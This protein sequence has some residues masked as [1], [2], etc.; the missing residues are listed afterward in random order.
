M[1]Y[2]VCIMNPPYDNG[3]GNK[4]FDRCL[5]TAK[6]VVTIQ[7]LSWLLAKRQH[8]SITSKID[9]RKT[10]IEVVNGN[11]CFDAGICAHVA[12]T[13]ISDESGKIH[14]ADKVFD[15]CSDIKIYSHDDCLTEFANSV[16]FES[17]LWDNVKDTQPYLHKQELNPDDN[18]YCLKIPKIRGS[19]CPSGG[20]EDVDFFTIMSNNEDFVETTKGSYKY[21]VSKFSKNGI[22]DFLYVAF[23]TE[24]ELNNF[25][26]YGKT[27]FMRACMM[28]S[29]T[30]LNLHRGCLSTVP[31]FDFSKEIFEKSPREIDDYLFA[32][33]NISEKVR[34]H[35]KKIL[36]DYYHIL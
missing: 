33:F 30:N 25:I 27:Y 16:K 35:I 26:R 4:V 17:S 21:L 13:F 1:K 20:K 31:W 22:A 5:D 9:N 34:N 6:S 18:W 14:Y 32:Q 24:K 15:K 11:E 36:P 7:P 3:F 10:Y 12:I 28:L 29:K 8:K 19:V 2:D 23:D